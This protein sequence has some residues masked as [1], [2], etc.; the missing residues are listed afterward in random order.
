[1]TDPMDALVQLQS[2]L[3]N[4]FI[5]PSP[6]ELN[7]DILVEADQPN[8]TARFTYIKHKGGHAQAISLFVAA[9]PIEGVRCFQMGWAT[10][11]SERGLGY[12][13]YVTEKGIEEITN[14]LIRNGV[15]TFYLE[16]V[17]SVSNQPSIKLAAKLISE[18][19]KEC[20]DTFSGEPALQFLKL[21]K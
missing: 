12:A 10:L 3:D 15:T 2:A 19:P 20:T 21:V 11:E 17:I 13:T 4:H 8:G 5:S 9:E 14:G 16:A 18:S 7:K 6:C 1:M